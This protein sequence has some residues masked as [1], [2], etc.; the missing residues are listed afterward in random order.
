MFRVL[1]DWVIKEFDFKE[2]YKCENLRGV[3]KRSD[4]QFFELSSN[5]DDESY[6]PVG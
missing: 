3:G 5:N 6:G 4:P 2:F 1:Y